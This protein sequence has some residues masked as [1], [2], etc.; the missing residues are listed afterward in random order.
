MAN[1]I[2]KKLQVSE[3]L[4]E[5][6]KINGIVI[7]FHSLKIGFS[8]MIK[9]DISKQNFKLTRKFNSLNILHD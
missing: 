8:G 3:R 4:L 1:I 7:I 9:Y 5:L 2:S 6:L